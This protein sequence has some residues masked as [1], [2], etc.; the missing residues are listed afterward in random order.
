MTKVII[1][2]AGT[3]GT[4]LKRQL[5]GH[6][7][8]VLAHASSK[9]VRFHGGQ[10]RQ[11]ERRGDST[12]ILSAIR[13]ILHLA[14]AVMSAIPTSDTGQIERNY[15]EFLLTQGLSIVTCSK[16]A[17]AHHYAALRAHPGF[18]RLGFAASVG[19]GTDML[20]MLKRRE[21]NRED[22]IVH[23]VVN[24][25]L[26]FVWSTI[27]AGGSFSAAISDAKALGY[28]E[29]DNDDPVAIVNGELKDVAMKAAILHN[30]ALAANGAYLSA[31][32]IRIVSLTYGDIGRLTSRNSR[33]RF[34]TTFASA[35][36]VD[37]IREGSAGSI[38]GPNGRWRITGGFHDV[39]AESPWYD[40]LRQLDGVNNGYMAR[41]EHSARIPGGVV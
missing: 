6:G 23:A 26:N 3:I 10:E 39:R 31:D 29:P 16:G 8:Q 21:L 24:G 33:F 14:D 34:I 36:N 4:E 27:Q 22:A 17:M 35:H 19:G 32:D 28:A 13:P 15:I 7:Y 1:V 11:I 41:F 37:Q 9:I 30:V 40:W 18:H 38:C 2:G 20:E 12:E 25:T 5:L